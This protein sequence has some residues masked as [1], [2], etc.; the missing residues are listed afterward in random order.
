MFKLSDPISFRVPILGS[1]S[2]YA[3]FI[4]KLGITCVDI[5]YHYD[6]VSMQLVKIQLPY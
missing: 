5:R 1:G 3:P 4:E 2:D 6:D